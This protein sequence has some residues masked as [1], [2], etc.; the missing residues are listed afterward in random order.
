M[1]RLLQFVW[2]PLE[3]ED[4]P[5]T[6]EEA[7]TAKVKEITDKMKEAEKNNPAVT[8]PKP[9]DIEAISLKQSQQIDSALSKAVSA[10]APAPRGVVL[11]DLVPPPGGG[12]AAPAPPGA[13]ACHLR[14]SDEVMNRLPERRERH[15]PGNTA[16]A[17]RAGLKRLWLS[18]G[19]AA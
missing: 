2:I 11:R 4:R 14:P 16:V 15:A 17:P 8:M 13:A 1:H 7:L 6:E 18:L 5:K 3:P 10:P 9:E 12:V 19:S